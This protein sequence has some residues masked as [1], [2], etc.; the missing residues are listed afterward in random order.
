MLP[1]I[2]AAQRL[3]W[4]AVPQRA[5]ALAEKCA[6]TA[7]KVR[8]AIADLPTDGIIDLWY[9]NDDDKLLLNVGDWIESGDYSQWTDTLQPL[10]DKFECESEIGTR[11]MQESADWVKVAARP[12]IA[13]ALEKEAISPTLQHGAS[14]LGYRPGVIPGSPN[15]LIATLASGMLGAGV[16][17]GAGWLG[18]QLMP[19]KWERGKLRRTLATLGAGL[20]ATPGLA[21]MGTNV[22]T[23]RPFYSG[24]LLD[25]P[26]DTVSSHSPL[27]YRQGTNGNQFYPN[28]EYTGHLST[29]GLPGLELDYRK[30][31]FAKTA[32]SMTGYDKPWPTIDVPAFHAAVN[33]DNRISPLLPPSTRA[34][35]SGLMLGASKVNGGARFITPM[36]V[37]RIAAGMGS[38]YVSGMLVG[39]VLGGL[40]GMPEATQEKLKNTGTWAGIVANM[41]PLAFRG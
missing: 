8:E 41:I 38:G 28:P 13:I 9:H 6:G 25:G 40:M 39:K 35:A 36:D 20:G 18:E 15:P 30:K 14:L 23:G 31:A 37:G 7:K 1:V 4:L 12:A 29:H 22:A 16:G 11:S 17:Y 10:V 27:R 2:A 19:N 34:A 26:V 21:W 24:E 33:F 32:A 5:V 3:T